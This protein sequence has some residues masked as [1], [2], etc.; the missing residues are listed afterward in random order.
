MLKTILKFIASA[1]ACIALASPLKASAYEQL[2]HD[3]NVGPID[4]FGILALGDSFLAMP[5]L[6]SSTTGWKESGTSN[7]AF[8]TFSQTTDLYFTVHI[9]SS[10]AQFAVFSWYQ[11]E[12]KDSALLNT[13][14]VVVN[15]P[16][17]GVLL[18]QPLPADLPFR[19]MAGFMS[20][21]GMAAPVPEPGTFAMLLAGL[22]VIGFIA[23]RRMGNA[24]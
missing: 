4:S 8:A 3:Y 23:R 21:A 20:M 13:S 10:S 15:E 16:Y 18:G 11:G 6:T 22:A 5:G 24:A 2:W 14:N 19:D 1:A 9:V 7:A 12:L 17:P